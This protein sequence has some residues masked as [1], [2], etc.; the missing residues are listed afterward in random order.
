M[1]T[2][3]CFGFFTFFFLV[4]YILVAFLIKQLFQRSG[5]EI[6]PGDSKLRAAWEERFHKS[7]YDLSHF[8]VSYQTK[9]KQF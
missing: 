6:I 5:Y 7:L 1:R 9:P 3:N 2:R 4:L 8:N